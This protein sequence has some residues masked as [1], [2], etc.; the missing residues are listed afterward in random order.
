LLA[1]WPLVRGRFWQ[2]APKEMLDK[3]EH[4]LSDKPA[5]KLAE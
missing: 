5:K 4:P 2:V 1:D 3:L